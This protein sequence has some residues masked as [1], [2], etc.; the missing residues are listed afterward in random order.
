MNTALF[1]ITVERYHRMVAAGVFDR[2][3]RVELLE[4]QLVAMSPIGPSHC[5]LVDKLYELLRA[6]TPPGFRV[7]SQRPVTLSTSEPEPD[8]LVVRGAAA[9]FV[10]RHPGARDVCVVM[11]VAETSLVHDRE[12]KSRIYA[13]AGLAEYWLVNVPQRRIEVH[14]QIVL[15]ADGAAAYGE[16]T[17]YAA[18]A[19]VPVTL[20][21]RQVGDV[22]IAELF[23]SFPQ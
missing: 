15:H 6:M 4:G 20:D 5:Y 19:A 16:P 17:V 3:D 12:S 9:D 2:G 21:G 18:D 1:P 22:S 13:A 23:A 11:E 8:L 10:R 14:R 7:F